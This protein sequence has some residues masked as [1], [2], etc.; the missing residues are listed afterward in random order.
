MDDSH[1]EK[2]DRL[3]ETLGSLLKRTRKSRHLTLAEA[4]E[5][6]RIHI[7]SLQALEEDDFDKL[8]A[9]VFVRGFIKLYSKYLDLDPQETLAHFAS[10][11]STDPE[12]VSDTPY[13]H[14]LLSGEL[15]AEPL[16]LIRKNGKIITVFLLLA[17]L[18]LFYALG[19]FFKSADPSQ[20]GQTTKEVV[21]SLASN[22]PSTTE[23][24]SPDQ[25]GVKTTTT[26][27]TETA[28]EKN[29]KTP[30]MQEEESETESPLK[31]T[32][33]QGKP[34]STPEPAKT[35][36]SETPLQGNPSTAKHQA[37]TSDHGVQSLPV[38]VKVSTK[39]T[40]KKPIYILE[41]N[42][43]ENSQVTVRV[44]NEPEKR[45]LSQAG[46]VRIWKASTGITLSLGNPSAVTLIL[47]G[48][49][50]PASYFTGPA[51]TLQIP[52]DLPDNL[53]P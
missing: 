27:E 26:G 25:E 50:I 31:S 34:S 28:G 20:P 2:E 17:T 40:A 51:S 45:Y 7:L 32:T 44:D 1:N 16:S 33:E 46:I 43:E 49:P 5:S 14:D 21:E 22:N 12:K 15:M 47:N 23:D 10:Q 53:L 6:T 18:V 24:K 37:A 19:I 29:Q 52:A 8:P 13:R 41:A 36:T 4:A 3:E 9:E 48:R 35:N 39:P 11:E 42:F 38:T 30:E